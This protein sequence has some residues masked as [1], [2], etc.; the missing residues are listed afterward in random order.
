M[1]QGVTNEMYLDADYN[2][3]RGC[4]E[5]DSDPQSLRQG[6]LRPSCIPIPP[7]GRERYIIIHAA[8]GVKWI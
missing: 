1:P 3:V 8:V 5:R 2:E 6:F 7:S 4:P